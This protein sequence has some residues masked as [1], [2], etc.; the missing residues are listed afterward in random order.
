MPEWLQVAIGQA[1]GT[2][3]G[4]LIALGGVVWQARR[5]RERRRE[6]REVELRMRWDSRKLQAVTELLGASQRLMVHVSP[7]LDDGES[8]Q[9]VKDEWDQ[10][11]DVIYRAE[12]HLLLLISSDAMEGV[13][14]DVG[15]WDDPPAYV[16]WRN[17]FREA[18]REELQIPR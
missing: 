13:L 4:A 9:Q 2:I 10:L 11:L 8:S 12:A 7:R 5:E 6:E 16:K 1:L 15:T 14:H 17:R 18:V 3:L